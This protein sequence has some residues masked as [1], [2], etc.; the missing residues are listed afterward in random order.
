MAIRNIR[1]EGDPILLKKSRKVDKIDER[2]EILIKDMLDTMYESEGVGLAAPQ[3]GILKKI[4]VID[5]GDGE[6]P[7][8]IINPIIVSEEGHQEEVEGCLSV[9]GKAGIVNRPSD[10]TVKGLDIEGNEI[11]VEGKEF[12][13]R[14]LSH[15]I[16]HLEGVLFIDK[17]IKYI[18]I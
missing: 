2:I 14:A 13:A 5:I 18:D 16:D 11:Q 17:V 4:I 9:P 8:I 15:E 6:E 12:L 7:T 1:K 10:I 3:V